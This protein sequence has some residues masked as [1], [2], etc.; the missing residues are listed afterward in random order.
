MPGEH[1][2]FLFQ[3]SQLAFRVCHLAET[4]CLRRK[5]KKNINRDTPAEC[6]H[7]PSVNPAG[8]PFPWTPAQLGPHRG[9]EA[10]PDLPR[11]SSPVHSK[12]TQG[13]LEHTSPS[14]R[15]AKH[16]PGGLHPDTLCAILGSSAGFRTITFPHQRS[17]VK[18]ER[19]SDISWNFIFPSS[20]FPP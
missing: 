13:H 12:P 14:A 20:C 8:A 10:V 5:T 17:P 2:H 18:W 11:R 19:L 9:G 1:K 3:I 15:P 16:W 7:G 6:G 4:T